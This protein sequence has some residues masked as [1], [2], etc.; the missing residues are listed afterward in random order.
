MLQELLPEYIFCFPSDFQSELHQF[1]LQEQ[2]FGQMNTAVPRFSFRKKAPQTAMLQDAKKHQTARA[3]L[4]GRK[5]AAKQQ[6]ARLK[7][8]EEILQS[9]EKYQEQFPELST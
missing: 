9:P 1:F 7:K 2:E 5:D 6:D 8:L 3:H 4:P